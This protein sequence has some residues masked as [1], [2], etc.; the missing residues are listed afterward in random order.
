MQVETAYRFNHAKTTK[1]SA[2][3]EMVLNSLG[4]LREHFQD[5]NVQEIMINGADDVF[6][7]RFGAINKIDIK[8]SEA[9]IR[10]AITVLAS[11]AGKEIGP[12]SKDC[13]LNERWNGVRVCAVLPPASPNGPVMSIRKHSSVTFTLDDYVTNEVIE[14]ATRDILKGAIQD[15]K[16]T[17]W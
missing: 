10:A 3:L 11:R 14:P 16:R 17:S 1:N 5:S 15:K 6:I 2:A 8:L 7:E 12:K 13:I 4:V 9:Q